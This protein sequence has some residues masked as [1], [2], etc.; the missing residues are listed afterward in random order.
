MG[1]GDGEDRWW[2]QTTY[3]PQYLLL[4]ECCSRPQENTARGNYRALTG[5]RFPSHL[6]QYF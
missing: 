6:L 2:C 5:R 3:N 1:K 4:S